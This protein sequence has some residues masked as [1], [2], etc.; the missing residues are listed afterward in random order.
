MKNYNWFGFETK[1]KELFELEKEIDSLGIPLDKIKKFM[2]I[3]SNYTYLHETV[4]DYYDWEMDEGETSQIRE[5]AKGKHID[6]LMGIGFKYSNLGDNYDTLI[7]LLKYRDLNLIKEFLTKYE[8]DI[9]NTHVLQDDHFFPIAYG[10]FQE[11]MQNEFT[12]LCHFIVELDTKMNL[13]YEF[14]NWGDDDCIN[15]YNKISDKIQKMKM[16]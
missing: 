8:I 6:F 11:A 10:L 12:E 7:S 2:D 5:E 13:Y 4:K 9:V 1:E 14:A 3:Y 16:M 15:T